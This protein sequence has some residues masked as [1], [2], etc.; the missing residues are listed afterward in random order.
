MQASRAVPKMRAEEGQRNVRQTT[1]TIRFK[2]ATGI[3]K[4][5]NGATGITKQ[6][7]HATRI[8]NIPV[9]P[10]ELPNRQIASLE[11][12]RAPIELVALPKSQIVPITKEASSAKLHWACYSAARRQMALS[13]TTVMALQSAME[14]SGASSQALKKC[15]QLPAN[16]SSFQE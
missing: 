8:T 6:A 3:T 16:T 14:A 15:W 10:Q 4:Q 5:P 13:N 11:L 9:V 12:P 1:K 7:N 2:R